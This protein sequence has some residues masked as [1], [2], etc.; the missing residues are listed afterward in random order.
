MFASNGEACTAGSRILV[1]RAIYE[2]FVDAFATRAANIQMG[3]PLSKETEVGPLISEAHRSRV[4]DYIEDGRIAGATVHRE[5]FGSLTSG[6]YVPPTVLSNVNN[7]MRI[8]QEEIFGPVAA[9]IPFSGTEEAVQIANDT[10]YGLAGCV[11][12]G[13]HER[14]MSVARR[15]R[16]GSV[17]I[18]SVL[19]R[20]FRA[21]FGGYKHSG[22]GRIGGHYSVDL[23]TEVKSTCVS[24]APLQLPRLGTGSRVAPQ[25]SHG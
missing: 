13:D 17:A 4:L 6:H 21:P 5:V 24:V 23:F 7:S 9:L 14:A 12:S 2:D 18:N 11:W 16:A 10:A 8:A 25:S 20:D 3:D 19:I 22:I 15:L 1:E